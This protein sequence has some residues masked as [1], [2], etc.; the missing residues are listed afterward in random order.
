MK[1]LRVGCGTWLGESLD[2]AYFGAGETRE[3]IIAV[4]DDSA[5]FS[6]RDN[7]REPGIV[8]GCTKSPLSFIFFI[9]IVKL[10]VN[11]SD[12]QSIGTIEE[13]ISV[14]VKHGKPT[15][16]IIGP[17]GEILGTEPHE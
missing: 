6:V 13:R 7:R 5:M 12:E 8:S 16:E 14:G 9:A 11:D 3:L 2:R 4:Y 1:P 17:P 15:V 10:W